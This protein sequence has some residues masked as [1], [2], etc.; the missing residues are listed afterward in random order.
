[1]FHNELNSSSIL[2]PKHMPEFPTFL[3]WITFHLLYL[4]H[5]VC[6]LI[7]WWMLGSVFGY[8]R[9]HSCE[10]TFVE[11]LASVLVFEML[12]YCSYSSW[13]IWHLSNQKGTVVP[14]HLHLNQHRRLILF[15]YLFLIATLGWKV[16]SLCDWV[17]IFLAMAIEPQVTPSEHT[18]TLQEQHSQQQRV[19]LAWLLVSLRQFYCRGLK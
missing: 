7:L 9:Q 13:T 1:M 10:Y 3:S 18:H 16:E 14:G 4:S 2:S 6:L 5:A 8:Y 15:V 17:C 11:S 12:S 19:V